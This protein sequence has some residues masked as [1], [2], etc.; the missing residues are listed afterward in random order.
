MAKRIKSQQQSLRFT[1]FLGAVM[2]LVLAAMTVGFARYG[3]LLN[4]D[5]AV[6]LSPQG[7]IYISNVVFTGGM[8]VTSTPTF[9]NTSIDFD[10][11]FAGDQSTADYGATYDVTITNDTFYNQVF[12]IDYWQP[13]ITDE[14]GNPVT[15]ATIDYRLI[16]IQNGDTIY[17]GESK[18]FTVD[19]TLTANG[20]NYNVDGD[21]EAEFSGSNEGT[22]L[23]NINAP[24]TG[25][26]RGSN[27]YAAFSVHVTNTYDFAQTFALELHNNP[28]FI[29]TDASGNALSNF[30]INANSSN[31]FTVYV[32]KADGVDFATT[33][34]RAN[35][36]LT[37]ASLG[38]INCGRITL[39]VDQSIIYTDDD[40]PV[41]SNVAITELNASGEA[42]VSWDATD[43][44][45]ISH[46]TVLIYNGSNQ[47]I[48]TLTTE[49][50]ETTITASGLTNGTSYYAK[51][52][53]EDSLGN[54][55]SQ[56]E[57]DAATT[58]SGHCSRSTAT[59]LNW[60]FTVTNR[61]TNITS[62]GARTVN[63]GETYTATLRATGLLSTLPDTITVTMGGRTLAAGTDYTYTRNNGRVS[64]PNAS[65]NITITAAAAGGC[66]I[67]GTDILLADGSTKKVEDITYDDLL[68]VWNYETGQLDAEYPIWIE[69]EH[70]TENY[71]WAHFSD[72]SD[73][74]T[75]RHHG[76]FRVDL[77][78]FIS[79]QN[80]EFV[81]GT[82]YYKVNADG[83]LQP[84]K[85]QSVTTR[86]ESK[87]YYHVVSAR[88]YNVI[89]N[90]FITTDG[91]VALS[92]L[93]G[94]ADNLT[95]PEL[96]TMALSQPDSTYG[97]ETFAD[98]VPE[99]M[100][101]GMRMGEIR[102]LENYGAITLDDFKFYL[103]TNQNHPGMLAKPELTNFDITHLAAPSMQNNQR[104]WTISFGAEQRK[105][106]E[107][108]TIVVPAQGG[109]T[110]WRNS[111]DGKTYH[112][113][114]RVK[115]YCATHFIPL[116]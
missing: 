53:G 4:M 47:L 101:A 15:D 18:T 93:Y 110:T 44:V 3:K 67:E 19:I 39:L 102:V 76:I 79:V 34:E 66:L 27:E 112:A 71:Q 73:L 88:Y 59:Q 42:S 21:M 14:S 62:N 99:Y 20:G 104:I 116:Y 26:L 97:Y 96:R 36:Y 81:P 37:S 56:A 25:D 107:N 105:V 58:A 22:V 52:Y 5:G 6:Q 91:T 72:G 13:T 1:L 12:A 48:Q 2:M 109:I 33:Y 84:V 30:T 9:T 98:T 85:L 65:G 49:D 28:H 75:T 7:E 113:G 57:I 108:A 29:I 63:R 89:A 77:N 74:Y 70:R 95:W 32:K 103:S 40:A 114:D 111:V 10:L 17:R 8:N 106:A 55:A 31:D 24:T 43:D 83:G 69:R 68:A 51:V 41:I 46:F 61:L 86:Y 87:N 80:A 94:F 35:I 50:D 11:H 92:N 64:I 23:A 54:V 16:G 90:G 45:T 38:E 82:S 115:I 78:R 100:Y 60:S